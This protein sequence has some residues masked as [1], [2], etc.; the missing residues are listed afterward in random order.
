M[1]W[2]KLFCAGVCLLVLSTSIGKTWAYFTTYALAQ[3]GYTIELGDRTE[4]RESFS[5]W[6]KHVTI[7]SDEDSQPVYVRVRAFCGS[8]YDLIY[9]DSSGK[10]SPNADGYYYYSSIL[11]GGQDT[12]A[13]D[14]RIDNVPTDLTEPEEFH[15]VVIYETT[16]V[17]YD[18]DG[19]P[20]G[21][22][23]GQVER[24]TLEGGGSQ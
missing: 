2:R 1:K 15:V 9:S 14:I 16:P 6:T 5:A 18:Q 21:D 19:A 3:G 4:L 20:Y 11:S 24:S 17:C 8:A 23:D 13:L 12:D 7:H 10:W 22:W